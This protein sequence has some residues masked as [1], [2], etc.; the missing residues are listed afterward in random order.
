MKIRKSV[1][2][3]FNRIMEIYAYARNFMA[4]HGNEKQ[5]GP[6]NWPPESLIHN[7][8]KD[9]NSYVCVNDNGKVIGVFFFV[10]GKDIDPC[11][12]DITEGHWLE[13]S[14]YGV[15][16]RIAGDGSEKGIGTFCINWAYEQ[17]GHLRI[18]THGDNTVMQNL[19]KK[20]GF[21]CCGT[22][23]VVEDNDPRLAYEKCSK[24]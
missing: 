10:F 13:D 1:E 11:Y 9:G 24:R 5:W 8:I 17:C 15:V 21:V 19:V 12:K 7:D 2:Q 18:D 20:L 6:T 23:Y 22:I 16:H 3:D 4:E 14:P